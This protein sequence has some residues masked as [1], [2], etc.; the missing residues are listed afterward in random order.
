MSEPVKKI[1]AYAQT[2][3]VLT[4]TQTGELD[5][6][7]LVS[8]TDEES[9][10]ITTRGMSVV[11][12]LFYELLAKLGATGV[13]SRAPHLILDVHVAPAKLKAHI[14]GIPLSL[15]D[16][17]STQ[18]YLLQEFVEPYKQSLRRIAKKTEQRFG[19]AHIV[20]LSVL[21]EF[22]DGKIVEHEIVTFGEPI[23]SGT[24]HEVQE[25]SEYYK[26]LLIREFDHHTWIGIHPKLFRTHTLRQELL[27]RL[28]KMKIPVVVQ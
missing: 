7:F 16:D 26:S 11:E 5:E 25:L 14:D 19:Q 15:V 18:T 22:I 3:L 1:L 20:F 27:E 12:P 2:P 28:S 21:P 8:L 23:L 9:E 6:D 17:P 13:I 10:Y 24:A 4:C